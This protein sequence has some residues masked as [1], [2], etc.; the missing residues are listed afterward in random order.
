MSELYGDQESIIANY[1]DIIATKRQL[2]KWNARIGLSYKALMILN[3][4]NFFF[5]IILLFR[6]RI[7]ISAL[8]IGLSIIIMGVSLLFFLQSICGLIIKFSRAY[9]MRKHV[10]LCQKNYNI[11]CNNP[12]DE[13]IANRGKYYL[14]GSN[15]SSVLTTV[16]SITLL[17]L[18]VI[19]V[20]VYHTGNKN[21]VIFPIVVSLL[22]LGLLCSVIKYALF[23]KKFIQFFFLQKDNKYN[24]V[25]R[26]RDRAI[27]KTVT[28]IQV[29]SFVS[30][31]VSTILMI[32]DILFGFSLIPL[33][34]PHARWIKFAISVCLVLFFLVTQHF[35][36]PL[37]VKEVSQSWENEVKILEALDKLLS[38]ED[39][40]VYHG[41]DEH[42][43]LL[44]CIREKM[45]HD[46]PLSYDMTVSIAIMI[47]T[48]LEKHAQ[49]MEKP[50]NYTKVLEAKKI[51]EDL[52]CY[53]V[54]EAVSSI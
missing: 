43:V 31:I 13:N 33:T 24:I 54:P 35:V 36:W 27:M 5:M 48:F 11:F 30:F 44:S 23:C 40:C 15:I 26:N 22:L 37:V 8:H 7:S 34:V 6:S 45:V 1:R 51:F 46:Y 38:K 47:E 10:Q 42:E 21:P 20:M 25:Y 50:K 4:L 2:N 49:D 16:K 28:V 17:S 32:S 53:N 52:E 12:V 9:Y 3:L 41:L 29:V 39:K 18:T 19:S 14:S